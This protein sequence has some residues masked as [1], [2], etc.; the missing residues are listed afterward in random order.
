MGLF[1][2]N[3]GADRIGDMIANII[4]PNLLAYS[5]RVFR[6]IG[7][8]VDIPYLVDEKEYYLPTNP[9]NQAH[10]ILVPIDVLNDLPLAHSHEGIE[11]VTA[12]NEELRND[13]NGIIGDIWDKKRTPKSVYKRAILN[14]P[15][16]LAKLIEV[17]RNMSPSAYDFDLDPNGQH[18]WYEHT[19]Q[20]VRKNPLEL[21]LG[22]HPESEDVFDVV[23]KICQKFKKLVEYN[24]LHTL[25]Y[26]DRA[27]QEP[28]HEEAAQKVFY[29]VASSYCEAN[30]LD[31]SPEINS[32]RGP[33]DFKVSRGFD[34]RI[35]VEIKLS[36]NKKLVHGFST[37]L[38]EY[39]KAEQ[40]K[41]LIY[42]V[43]DVGGYS[44]QRWEEFRNVIAD[45]KFS[46]KPV[47]TL[48]HVD[49]KRKPPAS[50]V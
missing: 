36:S 3:I 46:D 40:P 23:I 32:G 15:H 24:G 31:L 49:S 22:P 45:A 8:C 9:Y 28:K 19:K 1:E 7:V 37:Q 42:L 18:L 5:D 11:Q 47:P 50:K 33:V 17:Y 6:E 34:S 38:E 48:I 25:L 21:V 39:A 10:I 12:F 27:C 30:N 35:L 41:H 29:G 44:K 20:A 14:N 43:I 16:L 2:E 26:K 13:L 4:M